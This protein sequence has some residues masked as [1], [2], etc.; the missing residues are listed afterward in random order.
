MRTRLVSVAKAVSV[1][2]IATG[3]LFGAGTAATAAPAPSV[4]AAAFALG[5]PVVGRSDIL[6]DPAAV[7]SLGYFGIQSLVIGGRVQTVNGQTTQT[8]DVVGNPND[9]TVEHRGALLLTT[10][11]GVEVWWSLVIDKNRGV[12]TGYENLSRR[13][14]LFT[15]GAPTS[16]GAPL[17]LTQAGA[18]ALNRNLGFDELFSQ[19]FVYGYVKTTLNPAV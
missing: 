16:A 12:L 8:F 1:V 18:D 11:D 4:P 5:Q 9:G 17:V 13:I 15:L 14:D 19:G 6:V 10:P 7:E 2:A 3:L